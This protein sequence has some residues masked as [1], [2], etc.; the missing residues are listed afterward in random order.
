MLS[1]SDYCVD[2]IVCQVNF[3][4]VNFLLSYLLQ[5]STAVQNANKTLSSSATGLRTTYSRL[6]SSQ[7]G[8]DARAEAQAMTSARTIANAV[9][10]RGGV[11]AADEGFLEDLRTVNGMEAVQPFEA[12][13]TANVKVYGSVRGKAVGQLAKGATVRVT[14]VGGDY[15]LIEYN[16]GKGY[17]KTKFLRKK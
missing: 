6:R 9:R 5:T 2:I 17:V 12:R 13:A 14:A 8:M 7:M 10:S 15:A 3:F 11:E 16:G 4:L 1:L